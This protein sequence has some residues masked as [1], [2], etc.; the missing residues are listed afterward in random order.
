VPEQPFRKIKQRV[1]HRNRW[2]KLLEHEVEVAASGHRFTYTYLSSAPSVMVVA[3][4]PERKVVLVRQ[5]RYPSGK[6]AYELPGGGT[7]GR[8]PRDAA[9]SELREETG[10]RASRAR[11]LGEF[12]VYCGLSDE[13]CH[14]YFATGLKSGQPSLEKTEH[15][16][17]HEVTFEE[18]RKMIQRGD[19]CDGMGLAALAITEPALRDEVSTGR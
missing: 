14:V 10:Y 16:T 15:L 11:R 4:T 9:L 17:M 19:F 8:S 18:L 2:I 6:F 12:T 7:D 13:V 3:V 1:L 5:Y